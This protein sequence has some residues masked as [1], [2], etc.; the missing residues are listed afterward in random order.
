M[1]RLDVR[2]ACELAEQS[3]AQRWLIE[4]LWAESAVG[5]VG[6]EPKCCKSLL[7]KVL[8]APE[9]EWLNFGGCS[10]LPVAQGIINSAAWRPGTAT[11]SVSHALSCPA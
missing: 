5:I 6:G 9:S 4:G 7:G 8:T 3:A 1:S 11:A 2:R 10:M